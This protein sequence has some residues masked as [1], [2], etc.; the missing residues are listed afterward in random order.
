MKIT[1]VNLNLLTEKVIIKEPKRDGSVLAFFTILE[2]S[3]NVHFIF[4]V[5][6]VE[7]FSYTNEFN[8]QAENID[9]L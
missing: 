1:Y 9:C 7:I 3:L 5:D 4:L 6:F 2:P 8:Y